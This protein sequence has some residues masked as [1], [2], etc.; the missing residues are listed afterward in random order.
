MWRVLH[1]DE[2]AL[3]LC[4]ERCLTHDITPEKA[5]SIMPCRELIL[6][7][8]DNRGLSQIMQIMDELEIEPSI[9]LVSSPADMYLLLESGECATIMPISY[10]KQI[11]NE[12]L[13]YF[14]LRTP[15]CLLYYLAAWKN[16]NDNPLITN[17]IQSISRAFIH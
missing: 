1:Q 11:K 6:L 8:K 9:R 4:S 5:C 14:R 16:T 7:E 2:M 15:A 13:K 3:T 17:L 10:I 12:Y